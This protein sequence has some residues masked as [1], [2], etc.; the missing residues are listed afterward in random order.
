MALP[1]FLPNEQELAGH[2][3]SLL[4]ERGLAAAPDAFA[5][6]E[7]NLGGD[8]GLTCGEIEKLDLYLQDA[9]GRRVTLADAAA[10]VGDSSALR[11]DD[12]VHAAVDGDGPALDGLLD[13]L[14][15]EGEAPQRILRVT[16]AFLCDSCGCAP[17]SGRCR[18]RSGGP[19]G[20]A[21]RTFQRSTADH[22]RLAALE[23]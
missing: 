12:A 6:L 22:S 11:L 5:W 19:S 13:R 7:A 20:P 18:A 16:A 14:F 15:A 9:P 21:A 8:R 17:R 10:V 2:L 23:R 4:A 1:C 3:R